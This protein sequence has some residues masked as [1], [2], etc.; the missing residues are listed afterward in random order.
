MGIEFKRNVRVE[1]SPVK[2]KELVEKQTGLKICNNKA[3]LFK[4]VLQKQKLIACYPLFDSPQIDYNGNLLGCCKIYKGNLGTNV[5]KQG[6]LN[7]LNS[8]NV[9]HVKK[10]L[11][12]LSVVPNLNIPCTGCSRYRM[13]KK[14]NIPLV[15]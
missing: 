6:F 9:I 15:I 7:A 13:L 1:Y 5:F 10:V 12:D 2:N 8:A 14:E 4:D 3:K 11:T